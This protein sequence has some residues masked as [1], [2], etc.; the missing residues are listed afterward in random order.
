MAQ[1]NESTAR[2]LLEFERQV[3]RCRSVIELGFV[4][5]NDTRVLLDYAQA[6]L[7]EPNLAHQAAVRTLSGLVAVDAGAPYCQWLARLFA[8]LAGHPAPA[9]QV[10]KAADLPVDL[11][12]GW[13]EWAPGESV[14]CILFSP[15]GAVLGGLWFARA[16]PFSNE[17]LL[18]ARCVADSIQYALWSL[19]GNSGFAQA[20][21]SLFARRNT[22]L[23]LAAITVVS[24]L[25]VR[26]NVLAPAEITPLHPIPITAQA[27]GVVKA[28][29]VA[30]NQRVTRGAV[31]VSLDDTSTRNR[32]L[33]AQGSA[34][35]AGAEL[36]RVTNKGFNDLQSR[37][38]VQILSSRARERQADVRFMVELAERIRIVSPQDGI[39]VFSDADDWLGK[40]VQTGERI[41]TLADPAQVAVTVFLP[42][43]DAIQ[44]EA[45]GELSLFLNTSPLSSLEAVITQTSYEATLTPEGSVAYLVRARLA[46]DQP[47]PRLGLKGTAKVYAGRVPLA[48]YLLRRPILFL[49]RALGL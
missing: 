1:T 17:E 40:P 4:A 2:A 30:P 32:L 36:Q 31:L 42:A 35:S 9:P 8:E 12:A 14:H 7:W 27:D 20:A 39:A 29:H 11:T 5:V 46:P 45:G 3:R 28:I 44:L 47:T 38:E 16:A 48:Y 19:R 41:M 37:G 23:V 26:L 49:R 10:V 25:P 13:M 24:V 43:D 21:T 34:D 18:L 22:W 15:D 6:A 33:A